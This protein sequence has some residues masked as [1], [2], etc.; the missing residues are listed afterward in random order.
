[1]MPSCDLVVFVTA[2]ASFLRSL[3]MKTSMIFSSGSLRS[4]RRDFG[5][6]PFDQRATLCSVHHASRA[7]R[8]SAGL[9]SQCFALIAMIAIGDCHRPEH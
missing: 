9:P 7:A 2:L 8:A 6:S 1:M 3:Q 4:T 5:V